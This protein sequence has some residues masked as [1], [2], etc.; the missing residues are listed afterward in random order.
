MQVLA[1][2][3]IMGSRWSKKNHAPQR[4]ALVD[5]ND[6]VVVLSATLLILIFAI[7]SCAKI[8]AYKEVDNC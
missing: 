7:V 4:D 3:S 1:M 8:S 5:A 6:S 2:I